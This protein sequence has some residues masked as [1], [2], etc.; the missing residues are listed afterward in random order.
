MHLWIAL[1]TV[2]L[3]SQAPGVVELLPITAGL[4]SSAPAPWPPES[5]LPPNPLDQVLTADQMRARRWGI[6]TTAASMVFSAGLLAMMPVAAT[7]GSDMG[8]MLGFSSMAAFGVWLPLTVVAYRRAWL[9]HQH[10][11]EAGLNLHWG[12]LYASTAALFAG[13]GLATWDLMMG[14]SVP[15]WTAA[16]SLSLAAP[17]LLFAE[18]HQLRRS[19]RFD[20]L[21]WGLCP[22]DQGAM[23]GL[24][25]RF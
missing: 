12:W 13:A 21:S 6:G 9:T 4:E 17:L 7:D 10:A 20:E 22:I 19:A 8:V 16:A 1:S 5:N 25:L 15:L 23:A 11:E 14:P 3:A 2:S 24:S 18:N